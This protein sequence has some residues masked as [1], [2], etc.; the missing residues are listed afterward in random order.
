MFMSFYEFIFSFF[1]PSDLSDHWS[2]KDLQH[3]SCHKTEK[4]ISTQIYVLVARKCLSSFQFCHE[5][6]V[7]NSV[8]ICAFKTR[9]PSFDY[10][11][12]NICVYNFFP[13]KSVYITLRVRL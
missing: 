10:L 4:T 5:V 2:G 3:F 7:G 1:F 8:E 12:S 9:L 13:F 11:I 6:L